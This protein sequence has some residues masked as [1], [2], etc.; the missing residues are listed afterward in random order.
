MGLS[1]VRWATIFCL[2]TGPAIISASEPLSVGTGPDYPPF[3]DQQMEDGGV[4]TRLVKLVFERMGHTIELD[5][6]PWNRLLREAE[7]LEFEAIYPFVRTPEREEDFLHSEPL[8]EVK[9]RFFATKDATGIVIEGTLE[10]P[11]R[12]CQPNGYAV[13]EGLGSHLKHDFVEWVRPASLRSCFLMLARNRVD[14]APINQATGAYTIARTFDSPPQFHRFQAYEEA[15][16]HHLL[17]PRD[18][19]GAEAFMERFN[20]ALAATKV[21]PAGEE[22]RSEIERFLVDE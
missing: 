17:V 13:N 1:Q 21:S 16:T 12:I 19:P 6:R 2:V 8:S 20:R 18:L 22:I 7:A 5:R 14:L 15:D 3:S 11:V 9:L 4:S 10:R